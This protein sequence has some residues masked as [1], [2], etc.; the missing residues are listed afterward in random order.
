MVGHCVVFGILLTDSFGHTIVK[1][2]TDIINEIYEETESYPEGV[3]DFPSAEDNQLAI[4]LYVKL[5]RDIN[6]EELDKKW[7][8]V[9]NNLSPELFEAI[10]KY[11]LEKP[12]FHVLS[13]YY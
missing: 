6:V 5:D 11:E 7:N 13:G 8:E 3:I 9:Y 12:N 4:G 1:E 2:V 10:D